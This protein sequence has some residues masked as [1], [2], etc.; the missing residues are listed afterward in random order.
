M[1]IHTMHSLL[2]VVGFVLSA[3][4]A[5]ADPHGHGGAPAGGTAS[6][7]M[8]TPPLRGPTPQRAIPPP[9]FAPPAPPLSVVRE[10]RPHVE[11]GGHWVGHEGG[12]R[13]ARFHLEHPWPHGHFSRGIGRRHIYRLGGWDLR[14]HRFWTGGYYF[15]VAPW[16]WDLA[17][18]WLWNSDDIIL[19]EDPDHEGWYL[20]YNTRLGTYVH[21]QYEG[22]E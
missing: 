4:V 9:R 20:A 17:D 15:G 22:I 6:P 13:D 14:R 5:G 18:D 19:Y 3:G 21:V 8:M 16:E 11:V 7:R 1:R 10:P 2:A 12:P